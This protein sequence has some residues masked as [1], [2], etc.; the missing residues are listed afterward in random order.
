[1]FAEQ[2]CRKVVDSIRPCG[3][4]LRNDF[5][6]ED[7][8]IFAAHDLGGR[9]TAQEVLDKHGAEIAS[10]LRGESKPLH[11]EEVREVL[12][13]RISYLNDDLIIPTWNTAFV[14]DTARGA[15]ASFELM[16]FT[17]SQLLQFRYYDALLDREL[18]RIY[19]L[20]QKRR[21]PW[22]WQGVRY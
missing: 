10:L 2:A 13:T 4:N 15:E 9:V 12:G 6:D 22:P 18:D 3:Q 17:N 21:S 16:E 8:L 11:P 1:N 14:Y 20:V 7:Y 5:L 19:P